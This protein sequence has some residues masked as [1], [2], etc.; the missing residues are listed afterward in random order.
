MTKEI[1]DING[2][3]LYLLLTPF[4]PAPLVQMVEE[5]GYEVYVAEEENQKFET[6]IKRK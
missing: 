6:Y 1:H 3:E 4:V 5:K 2:D